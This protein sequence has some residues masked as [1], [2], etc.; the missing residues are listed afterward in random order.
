VQL[1]LPGE[2]VA[3]RLGQLFINGSMWQKILA[4]M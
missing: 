1:G 2:D 3:F 4:E